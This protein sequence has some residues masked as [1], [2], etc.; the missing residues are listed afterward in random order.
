MTS[1]KLYPTLTTEPSAPLK[2]QS[3]HLN[4]TQCKREKLLK[5]EERYKKK[6]SKC[7][8]TLDRLKWLNACSSDLSKAT[9]ISSVATLSMFISLPV[10]IPLGAVSLAVA[11][12]CGMATVLTKR[13]QKKLAKVTKLTDIII[14]AIAIFE[15]SLSKALNNG[16]MEEQKIQVLQ[17]L[18]LK[19]NN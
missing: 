6:Y 3:C 15:R 7:S 1:Y 19:V 4:V 18:H 8:K 12:F 9:G 16:K 2:P 13:H 10:S 14:L 11:S 5:L 17:D